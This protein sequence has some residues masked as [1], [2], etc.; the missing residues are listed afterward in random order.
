LQSGAVQSGQLLH[1]P[2]CPGKEFV[3]GRLDASMMIVAS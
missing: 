1:E 3:G 2:K